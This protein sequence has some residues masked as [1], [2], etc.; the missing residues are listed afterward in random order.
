M[1]SLDVRTAFKTFITAQNP[2]EQIVDMTAVFDE[3]QDFLADNGIA[4][5]NPWVGIQF[6]ASEELPITINADGNNGR[7]RE[8]GSIYIHVVDEAKLGVGDLILT[9]VEAIRNSLRGKRIGDIIIESVTPANFE[10][11]A[12]LQFEGGYMSGTF[13]C[14]YERDLEL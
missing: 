6:L 7:Y 10:F 13:I 4:P 3:L 1:S 5:G 12:A 14:N 9:R 11:G 2:A 8:I